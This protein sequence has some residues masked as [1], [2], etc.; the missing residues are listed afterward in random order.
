MRHL[1]EGPG[2][3]RIVVQGR[4]NASDSDRLGGMSITTT[5]NSVVKRSVSTLTGRLMDQAQL[6]GILNTL[7]GI[8]L[9]ILSVEVLSN[10][11]GSHEVE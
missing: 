2:F 10:K 6:V 7:Y 9:T 4:L 1:F 8:H 5:E 11:Q 3:Y